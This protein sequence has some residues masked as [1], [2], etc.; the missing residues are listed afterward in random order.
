MAEKL[1]QSVQD[2]PVKPIP[3]GSAAVS[4]LDVYLSRAVSAVEYDAK[5]L[6]A[7]C[8]KFLV[9]GRP[10]TSNSR[11]HAYCFQERGFALRIFPIQNVY[12]GDRINRNILET[13]EIVAR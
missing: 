9:G 4:S 10:M 12:A 7:E 1:A 13:S 3:F 5:P 6:L 8:D 2:Y 11:S